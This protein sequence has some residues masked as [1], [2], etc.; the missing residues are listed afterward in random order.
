MRLRKI[1]MQKL[2]FHAKLWYTRGDKRTNAF[3]VIKMLRQLEKLDFDIL[4]WIQK[5]LHRTWLTRLMR[6]ATALGNG[7]MVWLVWC[8]ILLFRKQTR[9]TAATGLLALL[10]SVLTVNV[11]LKRFVARTR[12]FQ[13][14]QKLVLLIR[15]PEDF[16]FPSGHSSSSFA[17][18]T[19]FLLLAPLWIGLPAWGMALLIAFSRLYLGVHYPT[20][21][22]CGAGLGILLGIV[23]NVLF[24]LLLLAPWVPERVSG[25]LW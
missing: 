6:W 17:V 22:L 19:V 11:F 9:I 8:G 3:E 7:G 18:S 1:L 24:P 12:P 21:V 2:A 23:A 13:N 14:S 4:Y 5:H 20:D 25:W 16:S 15:K 10:L